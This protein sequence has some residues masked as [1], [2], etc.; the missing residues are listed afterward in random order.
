MTLHMA[1]T[2]AR[3]HHVTNT[4]STSLRENA[5]ANAWPLFVPPIG[6]PFYD[7]ADGGGGPPTYVAIL[8]LGRMQH[9]YG[10]VP[11]SI[12]P[13]KTFTGPTYSLTLLPPSKLT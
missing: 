5:V 12:L 11:V 10:W 7:V 13:S 4:S 9:H 8:P 2:R 1:R 6:L 3:T